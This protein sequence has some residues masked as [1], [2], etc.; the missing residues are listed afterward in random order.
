MD[1][2]T[3]GERIGRWRVVRRLGSGYFAT[4]LQVSDTLGHVPRDIALKLVRTDD[5]ATSARRGATNPGH[6]SRR[7][8]L[9]HLYGL[10]HSNLVAI[11]SAPEEVRRNGMT[12]LAVGLELCDETLGDRIHRTSD[13]DALLRRVVPDVLSGLEF[14]H[15]NGSIHRDLHP[16][17]VME[18]E[19]VWKIGDFGRAVTDHGRGLTLEPPRSYDRIYPPEVIAEGHWTTAADVFAVGVLVHR[20]LT[21]HDV[22]RSPP[23]PT[24]QIDPKLPPDWRSFV[25][26]ATSPMDS[27]PS[28][29]AM[30]LR[31]PVGAP[32][33]GLARRGQGVQ[34]PVSPAR[35]VS[36]GSL[37]DGH[38]EVFALADDGSMWHSWWWDGTGWSA[39]HQMAGPSLSSIAV[40]S[41]GPR[42]LEVFGVSDSGGVVH[43]WC[44]L[45]DDDR[46]GPTTPA[47]WS[48]WNGFE[49]A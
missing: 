29:A 9:E 49:S 43:R 35:R 34:V 22:Y 7:T 14:L 42:H 6:E 18:R 47:R 24:V 28:A 8:E 19:E 41:L 23:D 40:G 33:A 20:T 16:G 25:E 11:R 32:E 13:R 27:R 36:A 17:N 21:G 46:P 48:E 45:D 44:W 12:F 30:Q 39:W 1:D 38:G 31:V 2:W 10:T 37:V 26:A 4:T 5:L 15:Q 3:V